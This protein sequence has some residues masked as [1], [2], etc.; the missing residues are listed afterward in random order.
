M[1]TH[2]TH[3]ELI[4]LNQRLAPFGLSAQAL[5]STEVEWKTRDVLPANAIALGEKHLQFMYVPMPLLVHQLC[6]IAN[7][8]PMQLVPNAVQ[9]L[10]GLSIINGL[11]G[12]SFGLREVFHFFKLVS[13]ERKDSSLSCYLHP[14]KGI[15]FFSGTKDSHKGWDEK[16]AVVE[17]NWFPGLLSQEL[18]PIRRTFTTGKDS[19]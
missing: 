13:R 12:T 10:C 4:L 6:H 19:R 7:I 2:W 16:I 14:R 5:K 8:H 18:W 1:S 3:D 17:G 15:H 9:V 11:F